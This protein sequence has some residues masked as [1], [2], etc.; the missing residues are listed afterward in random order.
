MPV[1]TT[2]TS[3]EL[4]APALSVTVTVNTALT[5]SA[6]ARKFRSASRME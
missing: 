2:L 3:L 6:A 4:A 5:V 1:S